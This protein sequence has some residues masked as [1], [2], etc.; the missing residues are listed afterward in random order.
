LHQLLTF[1]LVSERRT[2]RLLDPVAN[3]ITIPLQARHR[4][5]ASRTHFQMLGDAI[6]VL[7]MQAAPD[8]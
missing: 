8:E 5:F 7:L 3:G 6:R 1:R 4:L 2:S